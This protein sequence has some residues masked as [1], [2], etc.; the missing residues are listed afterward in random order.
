MCNAVIITTLIKWEGGGIIN[1]PTTDVGQGQG[2]GGSIDILSLAKRITHI[3]ATEAKHSYN[4]SKTGYVLNFDNFNMYGETGATVAF[5]YNGEDN[6]YMLFVHDKTYLPLNVDLESITAEYYKTATKEAILETNTGYIV[7]K[8]NNT[9]AGQGA[10]LI[11]R[12]IQYIMHSLGVTYSNVNNVTAYNDSN[13]QIL[14]KDVNGNY[15]VIADE[16]NKLATDSSKTIHPAYP[17]TVTAKTSAQ[18]GLTQYDDD[19]NNVRK[20]LGDILKESNTKIQGIS[21]DPAIKPS[22]GNYSSC[23]LAIENNGTVSLGKGYEVKSLLK[24]SVNFYLKSSGVITMVAGTFYAGGSIPY[25]MSTSDNHNLPKLYQVIRDSDGNII[26]LVD[27]DK[28]YRHKTNGEIVYANSNPDENN[29]DC[30][31]N[32][33]NMMT[34]SSKYDN[35]LKA[36]T[37]SLFYFEIPVKAGEY[38]LG[39]ATSNQVYLLYLDIG[40][41]AGSSGGSGEGGSGGTEPPPQPTGEISGIAFAYQN[42]TTYTKITHDGTNVVTYK[43]SGP[44]D[45][46]GNPVKTHS[47]AA[48]T[49]TPSNASNMEVAF[50]NSDTTGQFA[51]SKNDPPNTGSGGSG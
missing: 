3:M 18:L 40:G 17:S 36:Y 33:S 14:T 23:S 26:N 44:K 12:G 46:D 21:L 45:S 39:G 1:G 31:Y 25:Y 22:D 47:G 38:A 43:I 41:N 13:L 51:V 11:I 42:G 37:H 2:F 30:V 5:E 29:W 50:S 32:Y 34:L 9:D 20:K 10:T 7:G 24:G 28:I 49:F 19:T 48:I 16:Y 27:I 8:G 15:Y 6:A 4:N 35:D